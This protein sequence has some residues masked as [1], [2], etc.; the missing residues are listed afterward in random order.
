MLVL[1]LNVRN[2]LYKNSKNL[3]PS[4]R[5]RIYLHTGTPTSPS[6]RLTSLFARGKWYSR[7]ELFLWYVH[8]ACAFY[9]GRTIRFL[10]EG[11]TVPFMQE[12][13]CTFVREK[14][15]P[16]YRNG[17]F[18]SCQRTMVNLRWTHWAGTFEEHRWEI[19]IQITHMEWLD[20]EARGGAN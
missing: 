17:I 7:D 20:A 19:W 1:R 3:Y 11:K 18:Q 13:Q 5:K 12:W 10:R 4:W 14:C 16:S 6:Y 8:A 9:L 2:A 15:N